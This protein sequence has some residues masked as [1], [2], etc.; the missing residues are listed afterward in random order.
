MKIIYLA[1]GYSSWNN[2]EVKRAFNTL[3][4]AKAF[5]VGLTDPQIFLFNGKKTIDAI[6]NLVGSLDFMGGKHYEI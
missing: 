1:R 2:K 5:N 6:N 3:E 4:E